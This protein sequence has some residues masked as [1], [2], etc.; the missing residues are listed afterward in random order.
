MMR[1]LSNTVAWGWMVAMQMVRSGQIQDG[2]RGEVR[3][4]MK[5]RIKMFLA[6]SQVGKTSWGAALCVWV[7]VEI[8][9]L[10]L[11]ILTLRCSF[12]FQVAMSERHFDNANLIFRGDLG[13][14]ELYW[15]GTSIFQAH[16]AEW[17]YLW[18]WVLT[19]KM[20]LVVRGEK[21][22]LTHAGLHKIYV[23]GWGRPD[24][25]RELTVGGEDMEAV[26]KDHSMLENKEMEEGDMA[27]KLQ[28]CGPQGVVAENC[29]VSCIRHIWVH[30]FPF[31]AG[32]S[33]RPSKSRPLPL[34]SVHGIG[35][36]HLWHLHAN[37]DPHPPVTALE[38]LLLSLSFHHCC[39]ELLSTSRYLH[40][41]CLL[42]SLAIGK[43]GFHLLFR[44]L[45]PICQVMLWGSE[46]ERERENGGERNRKGAAY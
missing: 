24:C 29:Q 46:R 34:F 8:K 3:C 31:S 10:V 42:C 28:A 44:V 13:D 41:I 11:G 6:H 33:S 5:R 4:E 18:N 1:K 36:A 35:A 7:V 20:C 30:L 9:N 43:R 37:S 38:H 40:C 22:D 15:R 17:D 23:S 21:L 2:S 26:N 16:R 27:I 45:C 12:N 25:R 14:D 19:G 39:L 32:S